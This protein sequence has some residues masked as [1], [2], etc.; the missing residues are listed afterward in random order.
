MKFE[1]EEHPQALIPQLSHHLRPGLNKKLQPNLHPAQ[2]LYPGGK[3][4]GLLRIHAI[5][6]H[7][8]SIGRM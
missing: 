1:I 4:Q 3:P 2:S 8:D 5:E 7:D 6:G